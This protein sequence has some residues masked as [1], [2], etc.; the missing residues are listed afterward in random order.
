MKKYKIKQCLKCSNNFRAISTASRSKYCKKCKTRICKNCRKKFQIVGS[1]MSISTQ[2]YYCSKKCEKSRFA[3][4]FKKNGYW[5]IKTNSHPRAYECDFYYE[6]ILIMEKKL[7][8]IL[9]TKKEVV[10]HI[11]GNKLNNDLDNLELKT[12]SEHSKCHYPKA[13]VWSKDVGIDHK[14]F[15][16]HK[17]CTKHKG[18]TIE[19]GYAVIWNPAHPMSRKTG[20]IA[21]HRLIMAQY[22]GRMLTKEEHVHH[23]NGNRLDNRIE[24]LEIVSNKEHIIKHLRN[25]RGIN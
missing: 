25:R 3:M 12:R 7:G 5:C 22:L 18:Y 4:K 14:S 19:H 11:D 8:R 13:E 15:S 1:Q 20:Y 23:K 17:K 16:Q 21:E 24:N 10:H 6:H 2:G 9:D